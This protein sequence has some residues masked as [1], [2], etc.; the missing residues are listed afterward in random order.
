MFQVWKQGI[1]TRYF[2][3]GVF[4]LA[5]AIYLQFKGIQIVSMLETSTVLGEGS[6]LWQFFVAR[7]LRLE[8]TDADLIA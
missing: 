3:E 8:S 7:R 1:G 5:L 6:S 2:L 4:V